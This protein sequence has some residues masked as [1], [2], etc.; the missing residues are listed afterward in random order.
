SAKIIAR[1]P[2]T[3]LA[4][5]K[6]EVRSQLPTMPLGTA[7]DLMIGESVIA[8][9]NAFGYEHTVTTGVVSATKRDVTLNKEINYKSLIQTDASINPGNS[10]GPLLNIYGELIGVNVAIRAGAQN[11]G[12]AIPVDNMIHSVADV[13]SLR[14]RLGI[15]HGI[16][17][18]DQIDTTTNPVVRTAVFERVEA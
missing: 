8:I 6:I 7:S 4:L 16:S 17:V 13:L 9:G 12:F 11:I 5:L 18:T 14:R 3:D 2:E 15:G 10:G 1:D